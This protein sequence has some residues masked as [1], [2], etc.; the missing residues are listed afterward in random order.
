M[1]E[2]SWT[3]SQSLSKL[4]HRFWS[5]L[6]LQPWSRYFRNL[7]CFTYAT[8]VII[9]SQFTFFYICNPGHNIFAIY[10][11]LHLQPSSQYFRNLLCF[12]SATPLTIFWQ[13]TLFYIWNPGHNIFAIYFDLFMLD[14]PE[15]KRNL[16][17]TVKLCIGGAAQIDV[18]KL[19]ISSKNFASKLQP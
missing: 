1:L 9:F 16:I 19:D 2:A 15:I 13:F 14:S 6:H 12:T 4:I 18:A 3:F 10:F 5:S 8:P 11:V 7:L 17:S